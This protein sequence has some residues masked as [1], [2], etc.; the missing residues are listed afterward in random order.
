MTSNVSESKKGELIAGSSS[1]MPDKNKM[2]EKMVSNELPKLEHAFACYLSKYYSVESFLFLRAVKRFNQLFESK[3]MKNERSTVRDEIIKQF[4]LQD[5][6]NRIILP[7][8]ILCKILEGNNTD[9][10]MKRSIFAEAAELVGLMLFQ[11][12]IESFLKSDDYLLISLE[13]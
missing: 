2:L 8:R 10:E 3:T 7:E 13:D 5:S 12:H 11:T 6:I 4:L 9:G 1:N